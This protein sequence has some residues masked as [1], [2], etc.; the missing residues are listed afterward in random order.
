MIG[1]VHVGLFVDP[2]GQLVMVCLIMVVFK[3]VTV[4]VLGS[5]VIENRAR[6]LLWNGF[7]RAC[8]LVLIFLFAFSDMALF[9]LRLDF[10]WNN[11]LMAL[12]VGSVLLFLSI[13]AISKATSSQEGKKTSSGLNR[14]K[15]LVKLLTPDNAL[16]LVFHIVYVNF[17]LAGFCEEIIFRGFLQS[18]IERVTG[19]LFSAAFLQAL[20]FGMAHIELGVKNIIKAT[21]T[22]LIL[23]FIFVFFWNASSR[24]FNA[25]SNRFSEP[26][27]TL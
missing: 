7:M 13:A 27:R 1:R 24:H 6:L 8:L 17:F 18:R 25:L 10:S 15:A 3:V 19:S 5:Y 20:V 26:H 16:Q 14:R 21:L 23:S 2:L 22:G 11:F 4:K 9:W 12:G